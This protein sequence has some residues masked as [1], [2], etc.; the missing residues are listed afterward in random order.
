MIE[1]SRLRAHVAMLASAPRVPGT[2]AHE[3]A[4][5]YVAERFR[6]SGYRLVASAPNVIAE[7]GP[8]GAPLVV[9]GA[10]YDSVPDSPGA[11]D[12]ASGVAALLEVARA[13]SKDEPPCRV[14]LVA[15]D[16]EELGLEGSSAHAAALREEGAR[17]KAMVSLE[18]LGFTAEAQSF[19]SGV[20]VPRERGD[21]LAIVADEA[22]AHLLDAFEGPIVERIVI[23]S[24]AFV[25]GM[26]SRLSDHASF[27]RQGWP[28]LLVTDTAF[29]RNPNYHR[30]TDTPDTLDYDFLAAAAEATLKAL[31]ALVAR[32]TMEP[33]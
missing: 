30:P 17:V 18:M 13:F 24:D 9:V 16:L 14:Q 22:S 3:A 11:D 28:A 6:E 29:L 21:F 4:A 10:H 12:N 31:R 20:D 8:R 5:E 26:L 23:P 27:W 7:V 2:P 25:A 32:P 19:V 33:A 15:Y 1:P